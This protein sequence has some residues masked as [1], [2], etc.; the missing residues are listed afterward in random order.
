MANYTP[1][2]ELVKHSL[3]ENLQLVSNTTE[4]S[5][6][7]GHF[8]DGYRNLLSDLKLIKQNHLQMIDPK[9]HLTAPSLMLLKFCLSPKSR[10]SASDLFKDNAI[11][12]GRLEICL[13]YLSE[14]GFLVTDQS[15]PSRIYYVATQ[16]GKQ[17][18][19]EVCSNE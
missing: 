17:A 8:S 1:F 5:I 18:L 15:E 2:D 13:K 19:G 3:P 7:I 16:Y 10:R 9:H 14:A 6:K 12:A 11:P 4:G